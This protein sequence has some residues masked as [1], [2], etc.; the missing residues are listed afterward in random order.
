[1]V[2]LLNQPVPRLSNLPVTLPRKGAIEIELEQGVLI[3][4]ISQT[5]QGRIEDLLDKQRASQLTTTEE[6]ELQQYEE[7]DDYLSYLNRLVRN[8]AERAPETDS[9]S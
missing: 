7:I 2:T 5:A 6:Q 9:A 8:L 4:R 1:M 3:F